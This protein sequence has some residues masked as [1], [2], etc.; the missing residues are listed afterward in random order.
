MNKKCFIA[1][2]YTIKDY[3]EHVVNAINA[4]LLP[5]EGFY[6]GFSE[7]L[8]KDIAKAFTY[9]REYEAESILTNFAY[10]FQFG[11]RYESVNNEKYYLFRV[12]NIK[13]APET[14]EELYADMVQLDC[15]VASNK[16]LDYEVIEI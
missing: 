12:G 9:I 2:M 16:D 5:I 8:L 15:L 3:E 11:T 14:I 10:N 6:S 7:R 1:L 4:D 13:Y